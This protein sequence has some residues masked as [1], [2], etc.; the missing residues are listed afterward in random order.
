MLFPDR[1]IPFL[2]D[3]VY[4]L[5]DGSGNLMDKV[6]SY[7]GMRKVSVDRPVKELKGFEKVYLEPGQTKSVEFEID[8][9]AL[10]FFDAASH[11]WIAEPGEFKA[12][13][14]ASSDDVRGEV[15]FTLK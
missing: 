14:A 1:R 12:L 3:V 8:R 15:L 9:A 6:K 13:V 10:S 7:L 2:Y 4:S 11:D 5:Y